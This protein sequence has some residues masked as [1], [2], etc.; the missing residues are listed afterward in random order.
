MNGMCK[1]KAQVTKVGCNCGKGKKKYVRDPGDVMGGYKY[2]K[3]HRIAARLEVFKR[4]NCKGC[5]KRYK[6]DYS[7][8]TACKGNVKPII[9]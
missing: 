5:E 4:K 3:P 1:W 6:C 2:L 9:K 7:M 8:Y